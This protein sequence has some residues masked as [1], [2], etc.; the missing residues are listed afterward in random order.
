[1]RYVVY[2]KL[3][4]GAWKYVIRHSSEVEVNKDV[5]MFQR[6]GIEAKVTVKIN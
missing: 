4:S 5:R 6:R 2:R 3:P 1:M